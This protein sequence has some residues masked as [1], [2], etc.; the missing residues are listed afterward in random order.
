M[1][2]I[3]SH[4]FTNIYSE[5]Y[6]FQYLIKKVSLIYRKVEIVKLEKYVFQ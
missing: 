2:E 6:V 5:L 1:E 3:N 4:P